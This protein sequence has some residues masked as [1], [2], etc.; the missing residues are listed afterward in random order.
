MRF[1]ELEASARK[2]YLQPERRLN[3]SSSPEKRDIFRQYLRSGFTVGKCSLAGNSVARDYRQQHLWRKL[4]PI[5]SLCRKCRPGGRAVAKIFNE[6]LAYTSK[7]L[8][9]RGEETEQRKSLL[10]APRQKLLRLKGR[11]KRDA[12]EKIKIL[13]ERLL[14]LPLK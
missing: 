5:I 1:P 14:P 6:E 12:E 8:R 10:A 9:G 3:L 2:K 4:R 13:E 11:S 7:D